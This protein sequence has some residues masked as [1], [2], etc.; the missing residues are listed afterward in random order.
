M[1]NLYDQDES[2]LAD[3]SVYGD[4]EDDIGFKPP[5]TCWLYSQSHM[6]RYSIILGMSTPYDGLIA[7]PDQDIQIVDATLAV[8]PFA[9]V[10]L[11]V[12][13]GVQKTLLCL[14]QI[15]SSTDLPLATRAHASN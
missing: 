7:H 6:L 15:M 11:W 1:G 5:S 2:T 9:G 10:P 14:E 3:P 4:P 8:R 12:T 13:T